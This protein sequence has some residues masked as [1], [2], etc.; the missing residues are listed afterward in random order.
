[1][2]TIPPW[3]QF[4]IDMVK[5][6]QEQT[7]NQTYLWDRLSEDDLYA[8]GYINEFNK[9][10]LDRIIKRKELLKT[11]TNQNPI[12]DYGI[13]ALSKR[14]LPNGKV[15]YD[16]L[17][18]KYF[19]ESLI[20][21]SDLGSFFVAYLINLKTHCEHSKGYLYY[22]G[23]LQVDLSDA[24]KKS[25]DIITYQHNTDNIK[26]NTKK[27]DE[28]TFPLYTH[29]QECLDILLKLNWKG[30]NM[31][32][33]P[34]GSG[35]SRTLNDFAK[36]YKK[37]I[38]LSPLRI[39]AHQNLKRL[40]PFLPNATSC[41][42]D[43]D[44]NGTRDK[45]VILD[46]MKSDSWIISSTYKSAKDV[47]LSCI[48][49]L[50]NVPEKKAVLE[51]DDDVED[52]DDMEDDDIEVEDDMEED[53]DIEED[54]DEEKDLYK[55][56]DI[57]LII[58][59]VH[60][61]VDNEE[62]FELCNYFERVLGASATP[63][64]YLDMKYSFNCLYK[65]S[66]KKAIELGIIC[67]Y[68][69]YLPFITEKDT[70]IPIELN[71]IQSND[72]EM[73][74]K[75]IFLMNG[76]LKTSARRC[77]VYCANKVECDKFLKLIKNV[78]EDYH[79]CFF[80]GKRINDDISDKER[81]NILNEFES[82][83]SEKN[84]F[85]FITNIRILEE[86]V[87]IIRCDSVFMT[88]ITKQSSERKMIQ[89]M[90]RAIRKDKTNINKIAHVFLWT[91]DQD[92]L[93]NFLSEMKECDED[94][95]KKIKKLGV[96]TY[97][98][99]NIKE[100]VDKIKIEET[101]T[102]T[103]F[104]TKCMSLLEW[105]FFR[106]KEYSD[107]IVNGKNGIRRK[108]NKLYNWLRKQINR[109]NNNI[110]NPEIENYLNIH[111]PEWFF[112]QKDHY[113]KKVKKFVEW[114]K[115]NG[116]LPNYIQYPENENEK[117]EAILHNWLIRIRDLFNKNKLDKSIE[118]YLTSHFPGWSDDFINNAM[119]YVTFYKKNGRLPFKNNSE[120]ETHL[121]RWIASFKTAVKKKEHYII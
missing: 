25:K 17:Q 8:S 107:W 117:K 54:D 36:T 52:D 97:D 7:N 2:T 35:K 42:V 38:Y 41:L 108:N 45:N 115:L 118:A 34:C 48:K 19:T 98:V 57:L 49:Q 103:Y 85:K 79:G 87:D 64:D 62:L 27:F 60:N 31:I 92:K 99:Q 72:K 84:T 23:N 101:K 5:F 16:A 21:A 109:K 14:I 55:L 24:L 44:S 93:V 30:L 90:C 12:R 11:N 61:L 1:M 106:A 120:E 26:I 96:S 4:E 46:I 6:H 112:S 43:C 75:A 22:K 119:E 50:L 39:H 13:D 73:L 3:R 58:D 71:D 59:E 28:T 113:F 63:L 114:S 100:I 95:S 65:L 69:I 67:D 37:V 82:D 68:C 121:Y 56:T 66:M 33:F 9:N 102:V 116:R 70:L 29:Q 111:T 78:C 20:T 80:W 110:L 104:N 51:E 76:M 32:N 86:S 10:R 77:I 88:N 15:V 53:D 18:M 91:K 74:L 105:D 89:R 47:I 81:T 83:D 40:I 94:F